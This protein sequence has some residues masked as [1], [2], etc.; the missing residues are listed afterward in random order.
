MMV[1][2]LLI[3]WPIDDAFLKAVDW[4]RN[5]LLICWLVFLVMMVAWSVVGWL[6]DDGCFVGDWLAY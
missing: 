1:V 2:W 6:R 5:E 4:L 3:G